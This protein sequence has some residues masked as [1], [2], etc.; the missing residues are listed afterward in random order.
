MNVKLA[1]RTAQVC[2]CLNLCS[3]G[4]KSENVQTQKIIIMKEQ[5]LHLLYLA[6]GTSGIQ[7]QPWIN[8]AEMSPRSRWKKKPTRWS[9]SFFIS[10]NVFCMSQTMPLLTSRHKTK[11]FRANENCGLTVRIGR[12]M[13]LSFETL[14]A[15]NW[16]YWC[17]K[18][19]AAS[20][21]QPLCPWPGRTFFWGVSDTTVI[22]KV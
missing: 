19:L 2:I 20:G 9:Y 13:K 12:S 17:K 11:T 18:L 3:P 15:E 22:S 1:L 10:P 8:G 5:W 7:P 14:E 16:V 4:L 21:L 6:S